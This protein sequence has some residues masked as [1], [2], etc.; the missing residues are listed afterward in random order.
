VPD[1]ATTPGDNLYIAN[2]NGNANNSFRLDGFANDLY[3]VARSGPGS[4]TGARIV[5]RTAAAGRGEFDRVSIAPDGR[6]ILNVIDSGGGTPLCRD[7]DDAV[8]NCSSSLRYKKDVARFA[9]GLDIINRLRPIAFTWKRGEMRDIGFG[10]EEVEKVEPLLTFR[11]DKGEI[12]GVKY[13][14]LSAVFVNAFKEQQAQIQKQQEQI[15]NQQTQ[16]ETL[17]TANSAMNARLRTIERTLRKKAS[18]ARRRH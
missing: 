17:R 15:K 16:V 11:N 7:I 12:E 4:A 13:N 3:I 9:G 14:Q 2:T 6:L 8:G 10:A 5:F 1:T 18:S